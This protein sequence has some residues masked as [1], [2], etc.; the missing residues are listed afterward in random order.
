MK[1]TLVKRSIYVYIYVNKKISHA[2]NDILLKY[3]IEMLFHLP[4]LLPLLNASSSAWRCMTSRTICSSFEL[5]S[6]CFCSCIRCSRF[7][8]TMSLILSKLC[9][10]LDS[11]PTS[12]VRQKSLEGE[13][14]KN[15]KL[16]RVQTTQLKFRWCIFITEKIGFKLNQLFF[17]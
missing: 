11:S 5:F 12:Y 1:V 17:W 10:S 15:R 6:F 2:L 3:I 7:F 14:S 8:L 4:A 13:S 16:S 9:A